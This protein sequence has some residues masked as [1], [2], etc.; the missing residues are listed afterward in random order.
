MSFI[1]WSRPRLHV[2]GLINFWTDFFF[3]LCSPFT[4]NRLNS[5]TNS[6]FYPRPFKVLPGSALCWPFKQKWVTRLLAFTAQTV[7]KLA[8][9]GSGVY[10]SPRKSGTVPVNLIRSKS[11]TL[12]RSKTCTVPRVPRNRKADSGKFLSVQ[13]F[14]RIC[15]NGVWYITIS[16][17]KLF[18]ACRLREKW[19]HEGHTRYSLSY[20]LTL[21]GFT[22]C[23]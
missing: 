1:T 18:C 19:R 15:V 23:S 22:G 13:K 6:N 11:C 17:L 5:V 3:C 16:T 10:T 12:C 2:T 8:C 9:H 20:H 4:L 14:V 7:Q 21:T